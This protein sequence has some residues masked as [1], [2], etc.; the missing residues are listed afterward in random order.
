MACLA[1]HVNNADW[2][3]TAEWGRVT[4]MTAKTKKQ[5]Q[6]QVSAAR[7]AKL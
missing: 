5:W 3:L 1:L 6:A 2:T 7:F 4:R